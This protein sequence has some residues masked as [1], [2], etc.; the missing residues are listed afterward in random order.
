MSTGR[1][2]QEAPRTAPS[3]DPAEGQSGSGRLSVLWGRAVAAPL[4]TVVAVAL[5]IRLVAAVVLGP[6]RPGVFIPDEKQYLDL[7]EFVASG[8]GAE[9]WQP[10]YGQSLYDSTGTFM[11]PLAALTWLFGPHQLTG[12]LLAV[13]FGVVTAVLTYLLAAAIM[14][15][16]VALA[17]GLVVALV[18]SQV[19]WSSVVLRESMV[20][21]VLAGLA[22]LLTV[23]ARTTPGWRLAAAAAG[24]FALLFSLGH[25][26]EQTAVVTALALM[27][28]AVVIPSRRRW[29]VPLGAVLI[30]VAAPYAAGLGPAGYGLVERAAPGLAEKRANLSLGANTSLVELKPRPKPTAGVAATATAGPVPGAGRPGSSSSAEPTTPSAATPEP[31]PDGSVV[32]A[33]PD[34]TQ[35]VADAESVSIRAM[36]SGLVAV[37][38]RPLPWE[39]PTTTTMSLARFEALVWLPLYLLAL[40][41]LLSAWRHR[42]TLAFPVAVGAGIVLLGAV[43]Q[44]NVGTA[45]RHRGQILWVL[46]LLAG[47]GAQR[48]LAAR[49][50]PT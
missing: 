22:L 46:A 47:L 16:E 44:G 2:T 33:G 20:W 48:L 39:E 27:A 50:R 3:A 36:P 19:L 13:A 21:A 32:I 17:A 5:G 9:A 37:A 45:F 30:G 18:P 11:R 40:V 42:L 38:L 34:G 31:T 26:R 10:G 12:Q 1:L 8:R 7:A 14:R 25:L 43:T 15:R 49:R 23:A 4:V 35:Y 41:G 6:L 29:A 28:A 24:A